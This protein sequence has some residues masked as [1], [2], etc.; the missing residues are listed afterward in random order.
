MIISSYA[1]KC[2]H[3]Y[4]YIRGEMMREYVALQRAVEEA[5]AR[6]YLG[7]N[8]VGSEFRWI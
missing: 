1:L 6:G 7:N 5:Y 3:A 2:H 4:I 8:I